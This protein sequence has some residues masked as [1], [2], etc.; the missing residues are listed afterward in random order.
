MPIGIDAFKSFILRL[1][2]N[3]LIE[4]VLSSVILGQIDAGGIAPHRNTAP[5][6]VIFDWKTNKI[7]YDEI[8][9]ANVASRLSSRIKN[10]LDKSI[11]NKKEKDILT[12]MMEED[13]GKLLATLLYS[14]IHSYNKNQRGSLI[15]YDKNR[16]FYGAFFY[17]S[18]YE[19][20]GNLT[21][22]SRKVA[23]L[24]YR[25]YLQ[26]ALE[27]FEIPMYH[28]IP[29]SEKSLKQITYNLVQLHDEIYNRLEKYDIDQ[30]SLDSYNEWFERFIYEFKICLKNQ[31]HRIIGFGPKFLEKYEFKVLTFD[32]LDKAY[33]RIS[34]VETAKIRYPVPIFRELFITAEPMAQYIY[35]LSLSGKLTADPE[36]QRLCAR[37]L[38]FL[39]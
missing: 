13:I 28:G 33:N 31:D 30:P 34:P 38:S 36:I 2:D 11:F 4:P 17:Q 5:N 14:G 20:T 23:S 16:R 21:T 35:S 7:Y 29:I 19:G 26:L 9:F 24:W 1:E 25:K 12:R 3:K 27:Y 22:V 18:V 37:G 8:V 6:G 39:G 15:D 32:C 10:M